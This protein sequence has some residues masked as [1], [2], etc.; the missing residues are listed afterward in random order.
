[1]GV[2][3]RKVLPVCGSLCFFCPALRT[4]SRQPVKRYKRLLADI[5]PRSPD[6]E[7]NERK[8]SKL[9]E[10][11]AKNPLRIP[12][13][14][15]YLE[16]RCYKELRNEQFQSVKVVICIYRKLMISCKAQMPLFSSSLLSIIHIL[17]D[18]T[19]NDDLL[20]L[21]CQTLFDFVSNQKDGTY[22]FNLDGLI[23]KLCHLAQEMGEDG[24][25]QLF[26]SAGLQALSSM[27][28][29][30][31]ENSHIPAE[32]DNVVS[33]VLENYGEFN[34][35]SDFLTHE[36][37]GTQNESVGEDSLSA[38]ALKRIS[39]WRRIVSEK[40]EVV[41]SAEDAKNPRFWSRVCLCNVAKLAKEATT[42]R[43]VLESLFRYFDNGNL[44]SP[45]N[46]LALP[47]FLDMELLIEKFGQ[48]SHFL[49]S[50]L[51]KHL[52]HK[53]ILKT[54][55]MQLDIVNVATALARQSKVQLSVAIIGAFSDMMRHLRKSIHCCL[56]DANLGPEVIE[57]N[58]KF[59]AA[60][61]ECLVQLSHKIGDAGPVLDL[62]AVML[63]N[64]S[65][66]TVMSRTLISA[67][68]RTAQIVAFI[69][70]LSYQNQAFPEAL[71][72]QLLVA[73][74]CPDH[75]SRIGAHSIFSVVLIPSSVCPGACA[76]TPLGK[77]TNIQRT[78]SRTV[79][80]FSS[81]AA[82]FKK[83]TNQHSSEENLSHESREKTIDGDT[84]DEQINNP[85]MMNRL[86][87]TYSRVY[88]TRY[89]LLPVAEDEVNMNNS[90]Q[91][92]TILPLRL[93]SRQITLLLSSIWAQSISPLNTP[94][95]YEAIAH[96]Y[97]LV[98]LFAQSK[99][100]CNE[101]LI[102]S[103]QL[104]ISLR[105]FALGEGGP[106]QP[107]R[108]RSLFMLATSMIIFSAM[109]YNIAP[110]L[111]C[112]KTALTDK[113]V[114]PFL[115]LVGDCKLHV[116]NGGGHNRNVYGSKEDNE[117]ALKSL[118][119]VEITEN[120]SKESLAAIIVK[121][122]ARSS[123]QEASSIRKQLLKD[124]LPDDACP[125]GAQLFMETPEE[126]YRYG[127]DD[128]ESSDK[129]ESSLFT[130]GDDV[131]PNSLRI[132]ADLNTQLTEE[133][134]NFLGA[135]KL[136][137]AILETTHQFGR[138]SVSAPPDMPYIEM[139]GNCEALI[140]GKKQKMMSALLSFPQSQENLVSITT[141][142]I[143]QAKNTPSSSHVEPVS[144]MG[145]NPFLDQKLN[146]FLKN[147]SASSHPMPCATE[148]QLQPHFQLPASSPYD[149]FLKAAGC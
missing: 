65:N 99:N 122:I 68:Y 62:M 105:S 22:M 110:L 97:G 104:A 147:Q 35:K 78:L 95:N 90:V 57:W 98:L 39:S 11:A 25:V 82:L 20:V 148:Y 133:D 81:S 107:S 135:D 2:I 124:F 127:S 59:R 132:Q 64:M 117:D 43:R 50:I 100:S 48:N 93:S 121:F 136:L 21:G 143:N 37:Q 44:W 10:Y 75:E 114:D 7:P 66:I 137:D 130:M 58:R 27:V 87:S 112:A 101:T 54:P 108:R 111:F 141:H 86:K 79:S 5:F 61:D 149:N 8:I 106:L 60:V 47:V 53:N 40:G 88:S 34:K 45:Q 69:P 17:L 67:V 36:K 63:E 76:D 125:L 9:C 52:D 128:D 77:A 116:N 144:S 145:E 1:M 46:G 23:S 55:N 3:S 32:F 138:C 118:S 80:V 26:R 96:T 31:G 38:D 18:Q 109:A 42:V 120:Q 134:Q 19:G 139:A 28:W 123:D 12:K 73:M 72:H 131:L 4:R 140:T 51:I 41:V 84:E 74:V 56:D 6:E 102:Q 71:F 85:S 129:A 92:S 146:A 94:Q 119:A 30:M 103:F 70:N 115:R 24:R 49:L 126:T 142:E 16:Q 91:Q 83:L 89:S 113:T 29:F 15:N 14:T 33:V 13:I